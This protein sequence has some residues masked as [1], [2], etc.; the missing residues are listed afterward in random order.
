MRLFG[1]DIV[2]QFRNA[3]LNGDLYP[4]DVVLGEISADAAGCNPREPYFFFSKGEAP[5]FSR[6]AG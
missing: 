2:D 5:V 3:G 4:H 6:S 1:A